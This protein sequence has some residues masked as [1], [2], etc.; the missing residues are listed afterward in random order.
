M[1][2]S[3]LR[4]TVGKFLTEPIVRLLAKTGISPNVLTISGFA[5]SLAVA[6]LIATGHLVAGGFLLLFSAWFDLLDGALARLAGTETPFG[7]L[8]DSALDRLSEGVILAGLAIYFLHNGTTLEMVLVLAALVG[9]MMVSYVRTRAEVIGLKGEFGLMA[10]PERVVVLA[11]GLIISYFSGI[12]LPLAIWILAVGTNLTAI[13]RLW[14][15]WKQL[16]KNN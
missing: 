5:L 16:Q 12:V 9:S 14:E 10:R 7:A 2:L 3:K 15:G 8:L 11:H 4:P 1:L 13:I 6:W